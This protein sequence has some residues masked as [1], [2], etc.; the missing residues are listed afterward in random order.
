MLGP[1][2]Q[3]LEDWAP[4]LAPFAS[5]LTVKNFQLRFALFT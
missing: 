1:V 5:N 3:V 4:L 2:G